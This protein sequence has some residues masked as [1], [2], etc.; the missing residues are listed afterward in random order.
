MRRWLCTLATW[1]AGLAAVAITIELSPQATGLLTPG[2]ETPWRSGAVHRVLC[3][4]DSHTFGA[5]VRPEE[6]YPAQLQMFLDI[7]AP[8]AYSVVNRG[9]PAFNSSQVRQRLRGWIED[10]GPTHVVV[11]AGANNVW[12]VTDADDLVGW[13]ERLTG[14]ALRLRTVRFV[15]AWRAQSA[16]DAARG[17]GSAPS[18]DR[19]TLS[20]NG[21]VAAWN[22]EREYIPLSRRAST[23]DADAVARARRDYTEIARIARARGVA[24][25]FLGYPTGH[26]AFLPFTE[27]MRA[28]AAEE[29]YP[30]IDA[31]AAVRTV[32]AAKMTWTRGLHAGPPGLTKIGLAVATAIWTADMVAEANAGAGP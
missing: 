30:F 12:N 26:P 3:V 11:L 18:G 5:G 29:N 31:S 25:L 21:I 28:V 10:L 32:S 9:V 14:W 19:P 1:I 24:L 13:R 22:G 23:L 6:T 4:G 15:Q 27:A 20:A 17:G 2:R 7:A 8:G 16:I